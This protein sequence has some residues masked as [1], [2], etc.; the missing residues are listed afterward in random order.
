MSVQGGITNRN[1]TNEFHAAA[2]LHYSRDRVI[3]TFGDWTRSALKVL[4]AIRRVVHNSSD[5]TDAYEVQQVF[6]RQQLQPM[7]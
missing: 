5:Q 2:C 6:L 1:L 4:I 3:F 7:R